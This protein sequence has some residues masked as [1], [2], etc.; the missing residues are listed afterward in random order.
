MSWDPSSP[1][2]L[3]NNALCVQFYKQNRAVSRKIRERGRAMTQVGKFFQERCGSLIC[4]PKLLDHCMWQCN[5]SYS[6]RHL[7]EVAISI[8][9]QSMEQ[10]F[11]HSKMIRFIKKSQPF[12]IPNYLRTNIIMDRN[13]VY[14]THTSTY[15]VNRAN[16]VNWA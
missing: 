9:G 10:G 4:C 3:S 7:R 1:R 15:N 6:F 8:I 2:P 16:N 11:S 12:D 14:K 13:L 5:P